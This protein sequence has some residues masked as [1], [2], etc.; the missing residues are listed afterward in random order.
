MKRNAARNPGRSERASPGR[1]G[2]RPVCERGT[3]WPGAFFLDWE[4][5]SAKDYRPAETPCPGLQAPQTK[6]ERSRLVAAWVGL[7]HRYSQQQNFALHWRTGSDDAW[8]VMAVTVHPDEAAFRLVA[9]TGEALAMPRTP[10]TDR[11]SNARPNVAVE[12]APRQAGREPNHYDLCLIAAPDQPPRVVYNAELLSK[13]SLDRLAENFVRFFRAL[14]DEP[15]QQ[16]GELALLSDRELELVAR[17]GPSPPE[18]SPAIPVHAQFELWAA[19]APDSV[20]CLSDERRLSY[21]ELSERSNRLAHHLIAAG[22]EPGTAVAVCLLPS[23]HP[24]VA[25]LATWKAGGVY[26]PIDPTHP[27]ALI[28][29]MLEEAKPALVLTHSELADGFL[30]ARLPQ[31]HLDTI[32]LDLAGRE[33]TLPEVEVGIDQHCDLFF[34]S[35][36]TGR[37]KGVVATHANLAHYLDAARRTYGF[38]PSDR[39][40]STARYTFSI[41]LFELLLPLCCGASVRLLSRDQVLDPRSFAR[42]LQDVTVLHS[43]PS[44][45]SSLFRYLRENPTAPRSFPNMRHASSGGDLVTPHVVEEMKRVFPNAEIFVIYG[46][47]E[48]SCMGCTHPVRRDRPMA[49]NYVEKALSIGRSARLGRARPAAPRRLHRRDLLLGLGCDPRLPR[50]A[51]A[52]CREILAHRWASLLPNGRPGS[53]RQPR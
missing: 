9:R 41:S 51:G 47:T 30:A 31:V 39:F 25:M 50:S 2:D 53:V 15:L 10:A 32:E 3:R 18:G 33:A 46:C 4:R 28:A 7:L 6:E 37:P 16:V 36:T 5:W 22:V 40:C 20:A 34:T 42:N 29:Q 23:L 1:T 27:P 45:L 24:L 26:V 52:R 21:R 8:Q 38:L 14:C 11:A 43:G 12:F 48:I 44:L 13:E 35:G 17:S 49:R 19:R